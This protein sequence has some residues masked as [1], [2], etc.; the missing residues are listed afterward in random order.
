MIGILDL[1]LHLLTTPQSSVTHLRAVGGALQALEEFGVDLFLEISG[2]NLQHWIR[3]ILSLM[4]ST[5]LSV[6]S[7]AVDFVI[8]L[9]GYT[10]EKHGDI[11]FVSIIFVSVLPEVAA[12]EIALY[13]VSGHISTAEDMV[14]CLWPLRRS[15]ADLEDSNPLDDDRVDPQLVPVLS[16]FCR[17]CQAIMDG[18]LVEMRLR[19]DKA[20]VVGTRVSYSED[21][22]VTFDADEESLFEAATF[23][24]PETAPMQRIR[25]LL[26]LKSLHESKQ[27][28]V[29]AAETL[30]LCARTISDSMPHLKNVWR[31]S[32]FVL[33][34]DSRRSL[35]L[36]TVG[37][38]MG[39]PDRGNTE[40]MDFADDF[41]EPSQIFGSPGKAFPSGKLQQPTVTLMSTMLIQVAKEAVELYLREE[42]MDELAHMR[43]ESLLKAVMNVLEAHSSSVSQSFGGFLALGPSARK[44]HIGDE[45]ALRRVLA[46]ISGDMTKLAERLLLLVQSEASTPEASS[47]FSPSRDPRKRFSIRPHYVVVQLSGKK[48]PRFLESIGLPT[49]LE[50]NTPCICRLSRVGDLSTTPNKL[51]LEFA[52]PLLAALKKES[53]PG[54]VVLATEPPNEL[55]A[56]DES[57]TYLYVFPVDPTA[58]TDTMSKSNALLS[59]SVHYRTKDDQLIVEM[60]VARTFPCALSRQRSLLTTEIA[61]VQAISKPMDS[62]DRHK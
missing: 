56:E 30:Y 42:D 61:K 22:D 29:E 20:S 48:P 15:I 43:L 25:W 13:S 5:Y 41:L 8:S 27:K 34:S 28:W 62:I 40:V 37:E 36:D 50:F 31:P 49:F 16:V 52:Q 47:S 19:G 46:S 38:E 53:S 57:K 23:F 1:L 3:V 39:R 51:C 44:R 45:A 32:R 6:R 12:R 54:S 9:L 24:V 58:S 7:I 18:V 59:K 21:F 33:W 17:T 55:A 4:N 2:T 60:K 14:R 10:Y 26:T 35:W 11:D